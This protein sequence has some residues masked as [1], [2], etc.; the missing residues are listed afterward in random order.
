M[1]QQKEK[2]SRYN[3]DYYNGYC[4]EGIDVIHPIKEL[5]NDFEWFFS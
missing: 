4:K 3:S 5:V 1:A 2:Q